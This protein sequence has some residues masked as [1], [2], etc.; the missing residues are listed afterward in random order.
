MGRRSK[1]DKEEAKTGTEDDEK[2][3]VP[4]DRGRGS[5][6]HMDLFN[7]TRTYI[8]LGDSAVRLAV[9]REATA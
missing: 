9:V 2:T 5:F 1:S 8:V 4:K 3:H 7:D 6:Q